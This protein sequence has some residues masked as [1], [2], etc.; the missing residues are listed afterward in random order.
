MLLFGFK[1]PA[2]QSAVRRQGLHE[3]FRFWRSEL[4]HVALEFGVGPAVENVGDTRE[5]IVLLRVT[6][7]TAVASSC[8]ITQRAQVV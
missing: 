8:V 1:F 4:V 7:A 3:G 2:S 5:T 6:Y